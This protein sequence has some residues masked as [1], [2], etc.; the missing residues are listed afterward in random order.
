MYVRPSVLLSCALLLNASLSVKAQPVDPNPAMNAPDKIAWQ[1][2]IQV[3]TK[4]SG[5]GKNAMFK[6]GASDPSTS[7]PTPQSPPTPAPWA[8]RPP[9]VPTIGRQ[10]LQERGGLLPAVPPIP[11]VGEET[12]RNKPAFDFI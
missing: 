12:R 5:A 3:N 2:F 6:P 1:L 10:V 9:V 7:P 8:L 4:A 11:G